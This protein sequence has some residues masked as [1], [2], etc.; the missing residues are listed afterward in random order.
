MAANTERMRQLCSLWRYLVEGVLFGMPLPNVWFLTQEEFLKGGPLYGR[1]TNLKDETATWYDL[2]RLPPIRNN[3]EFQWMGKRNRATFWMNFIGAV[4]RSATNGRTRAG[5]I[6]IICPFTCCLFWLGWCISFAT[7]TTWT[8]RIGYTKIS[9]FCK[10]PFAFNA[11]GNLRIILLV[12]SPVDFQNPQHLYNR[13]Y[14]E[15]RITTPDVERFTTGIPF[16][17]PFCL[18]SAAFVV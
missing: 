16:C 7:I 11:Q 12:E 1:W 10:T 5:F 17:Y 14:L 9:I 4:G 6:T 8:A 15:P 3:N 13:K 2:S 18:S